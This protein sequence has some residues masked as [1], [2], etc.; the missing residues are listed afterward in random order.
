MSDQPLIVHMNTNTV[1]VAIDKIWEGDFGTP[2]ELENHV[3]AV[4]RRVERKLQQSLGGLTCRVM[5]PGG[6]VVLPLEVRVSLYIK[7]LRKVMDLPDKPP[8]PLRINYGKA[9][10][11]L[12]DSA[13]Y[14]AGGVASDNKNVSRLMVEGLITSSGKLTPLGQDVYEEL[15]EIALEYNS[16]IFEWLLK[17]KRDKKCRNIIK[18]TLEIGGWIQHLGM[19]I[20]EWNVTEEGENWLKE[21][22]V[23]YI[24][25]LTE[26]SLIVK[27]IPYLPLEELPPYVAHMYGEIRQVA[28]NRVAALT[29]YG[30]HP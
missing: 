5:I 11:K 24:N 4:R 2:E 21:H 22:T 29:P 15:T 23:K 8:K 10:H 19:V 3:L 14:N 6:E 30:G 27:A 20:K 26:T 9:Y 16:E 13:W 25:D 28:K 1:K 17:I 7:G 18:R 12:L